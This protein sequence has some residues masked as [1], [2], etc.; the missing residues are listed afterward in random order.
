MSRRGQVSYTAFRL[1]ATL[2]LILGVAIAA[3]LVG[4]PSPWA[5]GTGLLLAILAFSAALRRGARS[6]AGGESDGTRAR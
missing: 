4:V 3:V 6:S 2:A 1:I 5:A